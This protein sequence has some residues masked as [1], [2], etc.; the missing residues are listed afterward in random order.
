M[1][2]SLIVKTRVIVQSNGNSK[3]MWGGAMIKI[4]TLVGEFTIDAGE[5]KTDSTVIEDMF[6]TFIDPEDVAP[7]E[8]DV[9]RV[10]GL[11]MM[12]IFPGSTILEFEPEPLDDDMVY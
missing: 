8:G 10:L 3:H 9:D 12:K 2:K 6:L 4:L 5:I 7:W 1:K 11:R